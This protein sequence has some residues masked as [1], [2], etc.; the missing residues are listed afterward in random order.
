ML[1]PVTHV[2][3]SCQSQVSLLISHLQASGVTAKGEPVITLKI[4]EQ[5]A[6]TRWCFNIDNT[7]TG[8]DTGQQKLQHATVQPS[9]SKD[10]DQSLHGNLVVTESYW[11]YIEVAIVATLVLLVLLLVL[12]GKIESFL[13]AFASLSAILATFGG[14]Q[15]MR[16]W[17]KGEIQIEEAKKVN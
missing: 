3:C 6:K 8:F 9:Y 16:K 2:A 17:F 4:A 1:K 11:K 7:D 10:K 12:T 5:E 15:G 14:I 13:S